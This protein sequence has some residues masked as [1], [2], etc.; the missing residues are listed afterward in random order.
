[1]GRNRAY[2]GCLGVALS[3]PSSFPPSILEGVQSVS[4]SSEKSI[5]TINFLGNTEPETYRTLSS[6]TFGFSETLK[7]FEDILDIDGIN[8]YVD[9]YMFVG[10]DTSEC[11]DPEQ[12][13]ICRYVLLDSISY[14]LSIDG[15]FTMERQYSGFTNYICNT[16]DSIAVPACPSGTIVRPARKQQFDLSG[17]SIPGLTNLDNYLIQ[18]INVSYSINRQNIA[19]PGTRTPFGSSVQ[20]PIEVTADITILPKYLYGS[21]YGSD[22]FSTSACNSLTGQVDDLVLSLCSSNKDKDGEVT[23]GGTTSLTIQDAR[24][25]SVSYSGGDTSGGNQTLNI[26][27]KSNYDPGIDPL[28]EFPSDAETGCI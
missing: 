7:E 3:P 26:K 20:F 18:S 1:M 16:S 4:L 24:V 5:Q 6:V 2:Y 9:L 10:D 14:S 28:I 21:P 8:D 19:E 12:Y 23:L 27:M 25:T 11:L 17:T 22:T 15:F 13:I